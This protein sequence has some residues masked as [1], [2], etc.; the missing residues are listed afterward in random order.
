MLSLHSALEATSACMTSLLLGRIIIYVVSRRCGVAVAAARLQKDRQAAAKKAVET[1][2]RKS[3]AA[4]NG[5]S[6]KTAS[7]KVMQ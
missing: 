4:A 5:T 2:K 7:A 1:K 6:K 3:A